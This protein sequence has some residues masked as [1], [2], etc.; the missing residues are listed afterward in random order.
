MQI[1]RGYQAFVGGS[2]SA[3]GGLSAP[4]GVADH[5]VAGDLLG[6][7]RARG[8]VPSSSSAGSTSATSASSTAISGGAGAVQASS[9][10]IKGRVGPSTASSITTS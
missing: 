1:G 4:G 8:V 10:A 2:Q 6:H 5:G 3:L 7:K 9:V